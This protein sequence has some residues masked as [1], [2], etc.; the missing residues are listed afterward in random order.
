MHNAVVHAGK[1]L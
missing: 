1:V